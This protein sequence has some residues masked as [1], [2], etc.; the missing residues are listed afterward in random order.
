MPVV[1]VVIPSYNHAAFIGEAVESILSQTIDDWELIIIDDGSQDDSLDV[2][3]TYRDSRITILTQH[4]QG[5]HAAINRGLGLAQGRYLAILN[6]DDVYEQQRLEK[7]LAIFETDDSVVLTCSY[8]Q[9]I[10]TKGRKLGVKRGYQSLEPWLLERPNL[11]FRTGGDFRTALLTENFLGTTSNFVFRR[12]ILS[13]LDGFRCLRFVHDWDFALRALQYGELFLYPEPLLKY[14]LHDNNTIAK[15]KTEMIFEMCWC[16]A[17]HLPNHMPELYKCDKHTSAQRVGGLLNS[18]YTFN[19]DKVLST[20]LLQ[21]LA[22]HPQEALA[23][24][25]PDNVC[26][27]E[28]L[29]YLNFHINKL[30]KAEPGL[31]AKVISRINGLLHQ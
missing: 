20:M 3:S 10:N 17:M 9:V 30:P 22:E 25:K 23:L 12:E 19:A 8:I 16:L 31:L 21:K 14:R 6:S 27:V 1:S 11:S 4:N 15:D 13:K 29:D 2:L 7:L 5:A 18:L 24:L 26:R 28:Y